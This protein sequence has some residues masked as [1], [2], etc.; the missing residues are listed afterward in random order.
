MAVLCH[1]QASTALAVN[2]NIKAFIPLFRM[3]KHPN[4]VSFRCHQFVS[5]VFRLQDL[6]FQLSMV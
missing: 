2:N 6:P 5:I 1:L 4:I 3:C